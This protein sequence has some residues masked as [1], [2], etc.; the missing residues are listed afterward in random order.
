M[1]KKNGTNWKSGLTIALVSIPLSISLAIASHVSPAQGIITAIWAGLVASLFG[2]SN[3]N[4][5]GPTGA[6]SGVIA[7][8]VLTNGVESVGVLAVLSGLIIMCGYALHVERYLVLIPS[9]VIHGFTLGVAC[10]IGFNQLNAALGLANVQV[11]EQLYQNI[12]ES[13]KH[14]PEFSTIT[15][16]IFIIFFAAI[17]LARK[18]IPKVPGAILLSPF[19]IAIGYAAEHSMI[20]ST[21]TLGTKFGAISLKLFQM[22]TFIISYNLISA[23]LVIALIAIL[24]TML[25]AKIADGITKT[26][27]NSRKE[28][29]GLGLANIVSGLFGGIPA[30]AALARTALNIKTGATHKISATLACIFLALGAFIFM[31]WFAYMPMAAIA[32]ILVNVAVNMVEA[33][34]F[35]KL[36]NL[37]KR[38]FFISLLV[39]IITIYKDPIIGILIGAVISLLIFV[40]KVSHGFYEITAK[41]DN[42]TFAEQNLELRTKQSVVYSFKSSLSYISSQ[43]HVIRLENDFGH[44]QNIILRF[45]EVSFIDIDG[46]EAVDS[47][48]EFL[49]AKKKRVLISCSNQHIRGLLETLSHEAHKLGRKGLIFE[50]TGDA[51][52]FL[53]N[54]V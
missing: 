15:L 49:H 36:Y 7:G 5:I 11:H 18:I 44:Y 17:L 27:H 25:S 26:R 32:A 3:Y 47:I 8:C 46:G 52:R 42:G 24:E 1:L 51:V 10:I 50:S 22:P 37:D 16:L 38:N 2:G 4:I 20:P 13:I 14:V 54:S 31:P 19:G 23:S 30:T 29:F 9:S 35:C 6:L 12:F 34:H 40:E 45:Q 28:I 48:I 43:A 53:N 41:E 33:E 39:A 21:E